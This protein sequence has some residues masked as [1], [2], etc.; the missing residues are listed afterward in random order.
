MDFWTSVKRVTM[1]PRDA[2]SVV[3]QEELRKMSLESVVQVM[4]GSCTAPV[5]PS[6]SGQENPSPSAV[7]PATVVTTTMPE[8]TPKKS[9]SYNTKS[10]DFG[11]D[12]DALYRS[13]FSDNH[14][15][16][17]EAVAH[18]REQLEQQQRKAAAGKSR[19]PGVFHVST[20]PRKAAAET[21]RT[22]NQLEMEET[23]TTADS[24]ASSGNC[25]LLDSSFDD[26]ISMITQHTLDLI[27]EDLQEQQL[28]RVHSDLTQDPIE[29][30]EESWKQTVQPDRFS[31]SPFRTTRSSNRS[32]C[33]AHTKRS[34][35]TKGTKSTQ[36]SNTTDFADVWQ[37][38]EQKYW[39]GVVKEEEEVRTPSAIAEDTVHSGRQQRYPRTPTVS[40]QARLLSSNRSSA[41][42]RMKQMKNGFPQILLIFFVLDLTY[43]PILFPA[44]EIV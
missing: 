4:F 3:D 37:K 11:V 27:V 43:L 9:R 39:D 20:P 10:L 31:S 13:L 14:L 26:G 18:L 17:E 40:R 42:V 44:F 1:S 36:S 28:R 29:E 41:E 12:P 34:N 23:Q 33:T 7:T 5:I 24:P 30:V 21:S 32:H 19:V 15:K 2:C 8:L 25:P 38:E 22:T 35:G 6:S 16:A